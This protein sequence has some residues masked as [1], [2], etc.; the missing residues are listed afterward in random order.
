MFP[1]KGFNIDNYLSEL[2]KVSNVTY[3]L[4]AISEHRGQYGFGH[5]TAYCKNAINDK[6]Y[7]YDD[8]DVIHVP[9]NQLENEIITSDAYVLF[10]VRNFGN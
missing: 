6:W 10:Y 4:N 2:H 1:I 7:E 8:D 5:Y 9:Y 3:D